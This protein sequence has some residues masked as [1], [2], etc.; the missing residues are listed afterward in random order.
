LKI[1]ER[2]AKK[3]AIF[4]L[5]F[6]LFNNKLK[7]MKKLIV[8]AACVLGSLSPLVCENVY[9]QT[10]QSVSTMTCAGRSWVSYEDAMNKA[11]RSIPNGWI[12]VSPRYGKS[13]R[14][15]IVILTIRKA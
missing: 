6:L 2:S 5:T 7:A 11:T 14:E 10:K 13:G 1:Y 8:I 15:Y 3:K 9:A 4:D 12:V